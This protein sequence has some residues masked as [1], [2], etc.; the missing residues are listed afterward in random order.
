MLLS[1]ETRRIPTP[2]N[3]ANTLTRNN[4]EFAGVVVY[5]FALAIIFAITII[6]MLSQSGNNTNEKAIKD[7][8]PKVMAISANRL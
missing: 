7:N 8:Q 1:D 4:I 2:V 6:V 3:G 5:F